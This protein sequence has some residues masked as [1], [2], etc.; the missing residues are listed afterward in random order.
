MQLVSRKYW[1]LS[2]S[3]WLNDVGSDRLPCMHQTLA[4]MLLL[5]FDYLSFPALQMLRIKTVFLA[6]QCYPCKQ[7]GIRAN[8]KWRCGLVARAHGCMV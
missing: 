6:P 1:V 3:E 4:G 8:G 5:A 7:E 2:A